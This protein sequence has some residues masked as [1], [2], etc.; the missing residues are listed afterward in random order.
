MRCSG[1]STKSRTPDS[2]R[3]PWGSWPE[4]WTKRSTASRPHRRTGQAWTRSRSAARG[5][6]RNR[7]CRTARGGP[8]I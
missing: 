6:R 1:L 7:S 4:F 5:R 2:L 3:R 8:G